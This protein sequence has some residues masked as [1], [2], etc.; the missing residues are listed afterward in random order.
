MRSTARAAGFDRV[1]RIAV[2]FDQPIDRRA[3]TAAAAARAA[4]LSDL[5]AATSAG[6]DASSNRVVVDCVAVAHQHDS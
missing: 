1:L 3:A 6:V 2:Q 5:V 4:G